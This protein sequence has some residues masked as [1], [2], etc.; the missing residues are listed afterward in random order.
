MLVPAAVWG[1]DGWWDLVAD[2]GDTQIPARVS[3]YCGLGCGD[4]PV[5]AEGCWVV[6]R[7]IGAVCS[8]SPCALL[9]LSSS[10]SPPPALLSSGSPPTF[11]ASVAQVADVAVDGNGGDGNAAV[12]LYSGIKKPS[13]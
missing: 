1:V 12:Q 3:T 9:V 5:K 7:S 11:V 2:P 4:V 8:C 10:C 6:V 13:H